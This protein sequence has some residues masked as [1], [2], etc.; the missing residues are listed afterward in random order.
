[1]GRCAWKD[2]AESSQSKKMSF[3]SQNFPLLHFLCMVVLFQEQIYLIGAC[4]HFEGA[5]LSSPKAANLSRLPCQAARPLNLLLFNHFWDRLNL[6]RQVAYP[7]HKSSSRSREP[8]WGKWRIW[9]TKAG[10]CKTGFSH[11]A[12]VTFPVSDQSASHSGLVIW[13]TGWTAEPAWFPKPTCSSCRVKWDRRNVLALADDCVVY[14][15]VGQKV[16][17]ELWWGIALCMGSWCKTREQLT[18][19]CVSF[20]ASWPGHVSLLQLSSHP[21]KAVDKLHH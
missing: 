17:L 6:V 19:N 9:K 11:V 16:A 1:M 7:R 21:H 10:K 3:K 14:F 5:G 8:A 12:K 18:P 2:H 20:H 15:N 13:R 4:V